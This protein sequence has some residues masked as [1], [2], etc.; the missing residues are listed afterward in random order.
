[1]DA[2]AA[3]RPKLCPYLHLPAQSGSSAV[4]RAMRRGYDRDGYLT[5]I[6]GLRQRMPELRFGGDII[7]GFPSESE[8]D[9][10][11]TLSLVERVEYDTLYSFCYSPRPGTSALEYGD[12]LSQRAK[13]ERLRKLQELQKGIQEQRNTHWIGK[14]VE[15]LVKG[16]SKRDPG[17][18]T[19]RTPE[20]RVVNFSGTSAAG[21]LERVNIRG[22]TAYALDGTTQS[23]ERGAAPRVDRRGVPRIY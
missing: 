7:V 1:M 9:F 15:V 17:K 22:A 19:G 21:R 11:Q 16:R 18:W 8:A 6:D 4:L 5:K 2:M 23:A 10:E 20:S 13:L 14:Q 12:P 3:A